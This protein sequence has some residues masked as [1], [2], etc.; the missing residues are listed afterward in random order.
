MPWIPPPTHLWNP[1]A[2][3]S[4]SPDISAASNPNSQLT[5]SVFCTL[6]L[7][8]LVFLARL[9]SRSPSLQLGGTSLPCA[10]PPVRN[11]FSCSPL[12]ASSDASFAV[13]LS[14][15]PLSTDFADDSAWQ[16][17]AFFCISRLLRATDTVLFYHLFHAYFSIWA[18]S[19]LKEGAKYH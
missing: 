5:L 13:Y 12:A 6:A 18:V 15:T 16:I 8:N 1:L 9:P 14:G 10:V 17:S 2:P 7:P 3:N 4:W 19:S 11:G